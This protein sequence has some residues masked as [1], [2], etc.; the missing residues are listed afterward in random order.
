MTRLSLNISALIICCLSITLATFSK[1]EAVSYV[2]WLVT[3]LIC[4]GVFFSDLT[5][6][7]NTTKK[8]INLP[9]DI[10]SLN[11]DNLKKTGELV[12]V[13]L[14]TCEIKDS[15]T[16][17]LLHDDFTQTSTKTDFVERDTRHPRGRYIYVER[18][19]GGSKYE[20]VSRPTHYSTK[21]IQMLLGSTQTFKLYIDKSNPRNY[22][23]DTPF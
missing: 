15:S 6:F 14:G 11:V 13:T 3:I 4:I 8:I 20:Y 22:Y 16:Y 5:T 7:F 9:K 12:I 19:Y 18:N 2:S 10:I 1:S 21:Y 17:E 23:F